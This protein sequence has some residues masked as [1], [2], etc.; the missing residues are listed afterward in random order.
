MKLTK[1]QKIVMD[2]IFK[3]L[4]KKEALYWEL[5]IKSCLFNKS[6]YRYA[7]NEILVDFLSD[8][9]LILSIIEQPIGNLQKKNSVKVLF[10][11]N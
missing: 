4:G 11:K 9:F 7:K 8:R 10:G 2:N 3:L 1:N 5:K 6:I